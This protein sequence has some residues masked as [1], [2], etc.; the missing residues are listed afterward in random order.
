ML[1]ALRKSQTCSSFVAIMALTPSTNIMPSKISTKLS[2]EWR[3]KHRGTESL[4]TSRIGPNSTDSTND[5]FVNYDTTVHE[6][7]LINNNN[8]INGWTHRNYRG[9]EKCNRPN[10]VKSSNKAQITFR[11]I[12]KKT[13]WTLKLDPQSPQNPQSAFSRTEKVETK[14]LRVIFEI[15]LKIMNEYQKMEATIDSY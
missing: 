9:K 1:A 3:R 15:T 13:Q 10:E 12:I 14:L 8:N 7:W 4:S 5:L 2:T 6:L 11:L